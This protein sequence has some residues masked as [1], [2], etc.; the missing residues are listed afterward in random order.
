MTFGTLTL[1]GHKAELTDRG[2]Q[3][4]DPALLKHLQIFYDPKKW[5][6]GQGYIAGLVQ[7]AAE[8]MGATFQISESKRPSGE[9]IY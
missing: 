8:E 2:W 5:G 9:V 6:P 1:K 7:E 3:S 4:N